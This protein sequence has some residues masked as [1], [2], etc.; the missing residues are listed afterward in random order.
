MADAKPEVVLN[1][2]KVMIDPKHEKKIEKQLEALSPELIPSKHLQRTLYGTEL[3]AT[4][5]ELIKI[6]KWSRGI[7]KQ[8]E[9]ILRLRDLELLPFGTQ[10][11][12]CAN[13]RIEYQ[14]TGAAAVDPDT[15]S[16]QVL[17]P[18]T[19]N[20]LTTLP[21]GGPPTYI[22]PICFWLERALATY[23]NPPFSMRNPAASGKIQVV[24]N[25]AS[26]GSATPST[27][28]LN[29]AL[30]PDV[31]CA[32]AVHELFHMVQFEYTGTGTWRSGMMEGGATWAEDTAA[33]FMNRYLDEAGAN[34]NGSGY[35]IRPH[36]SLESTSFRYKTSLFWRYIAEQHSAQVGIGDEPLIG[37]ETYWR[38]IEECE[39]GSWGSEDIKRAIRTLSWYQDFYEFSYL[40][41][42]RQDLTNGETT[43]GN[44]ALACYL[45]DLGVNTPDR[46][47]DFM[48]DE[49]NIYIDDALFPLLGNP[50]QTT[51]A[52]VDTTNGTVSTTLADNFSTALARFASR[53]REIAIDPGV[54]YVSVQF[55]ASAGLSS[56]IFQLVLI[57]ADNTVREIYRT[58]KASYLKQF[59][60]LRD[61]QKLNRVV[62]VVTGGASSGN[63]T[64]ATQSTTPTPDVMVT[65]WHSVMKTE[66]EINSF[67]WA[68]TWVS[69][70]IWVDNTLDGIADGAV[71]FNFNNKLHIHTIGS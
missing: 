70:D 49:E 6:K 66:Y 16:Q 18:S 20:V 3:L 28:Y 71:F 59:P 17:D 34:F 1:L 37:V 9:D 51:L 12:E 24:V 29:N 62:A 47:F 10:I 33:E 52:S 35:M 44:F 40:D 4:P 50:L 21:A 61:G 60:N 27:F 57:N 7:A 48:E 46:R 5:R 38:I 43:M 2:A 68:W 54:T 39:A 56:S 25:S 15:S 26:F 19:T 8:L 69:P 64:L 55:T 31:L 45:K 63:F 13:F 58:D 32:V 65:R 22:K 30:S 42:A 23:I 36:I 14:N 53:Y 67:N 11:H 41:P